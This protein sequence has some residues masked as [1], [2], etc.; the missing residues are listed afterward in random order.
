MTVIAHVK[1]S[2]LMLTLIIST[3]IFSIFNNQL[4]PFKYST[5]SQAEVAVTC[6]VV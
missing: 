3:L 5:S 6:Q 2:M 1:F 4:F